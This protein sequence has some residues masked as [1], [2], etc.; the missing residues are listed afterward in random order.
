MLQN[1]E[2]NALF[3]M[4]AMKEEGIDSRRHLERVVN[5]SEVVEIHNAVLCLLAACCCR[6]AVGSAVCSFIVS[7]SG[8]SRLAQV[9]MM[10]LL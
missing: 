4:H 5:V 3:H 8:W 7:A 6:R 10:C 9:E 2:Q 1:K